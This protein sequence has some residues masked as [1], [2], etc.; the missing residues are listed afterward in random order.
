MFTG[1]RTGIDLS[2]FVSPIIPLRSFALAFFCFFVLIMSFPP[3]PLFLYHIFL[4]AIIVSSL[5]KGFCVAATFPTSLDVL[6][7]SGCTF[8]VVAVLQEDQTLAICGLFNIGGRK[9]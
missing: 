6:C 4:S 1:L 2:L 8:I 3:D 7:L 5:F 9:M